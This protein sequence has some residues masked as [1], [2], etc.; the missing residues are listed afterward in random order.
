M[1]PKAHS[2]EPNPSQTTL[3]V[4][5]EEVR[6]ETREINLILNTLAIYTK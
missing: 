2:P 6:W 4:Y 1:T 5:A 3:R